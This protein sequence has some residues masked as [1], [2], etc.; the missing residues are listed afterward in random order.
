MSGRRTSQLLR[1]LCAAR[2]DRQVRPR[3]ALVGPRRVRSVEGEREDGA[4]VRIACRVNCM[5]R[6]AQFIAH[7]G[8]DCA[9]IC[10]S[11]A[12]RSGRKAAARTRRP[13]GR[14]RARTAMLV[15]GSRAAF[16]GGVFYFR[17]PRPTGSTT[18]RYRYL[19]KCS[20]RTNS[21]SPARRAHMCAHL[22]DAYVD[23]D[24]SMAAL[25]PCARRGHV[26]AICMDSLIAR[27]PPG[28]E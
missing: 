2:E 7:R 19:Q 23:T 24:A 27:L 25:R 18:P 17:L 14:P 16:P 6:A 26:G 11:T 1:T 21:S 28:S 9:P 4:T 3:A 13:Q 22:Q 20:S 12:V 10:A 15:T 5:A 8:A